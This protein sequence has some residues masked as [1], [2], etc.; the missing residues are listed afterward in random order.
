[1]GIPLLTLA[2]R[3]IYLV[4]QVMAA[5]LTVVLLNFLYYI[6]VKSVIRV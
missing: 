6:G 4:S 5:S 3:W 2:A 1:M